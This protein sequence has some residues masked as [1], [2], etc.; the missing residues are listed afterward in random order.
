MEQLYEEERQA[1]TDG[2]TDRLRDVQHRIIGACKTDEE[3]VAALRLLTN[4]RKQ[5]PSCIKALIKT[6]YESK[7]PIGF[8]NALL[9]DVIESKIYLEEERLYISEHIKLLHGNNIPEAYEAVRHVPVETFTSVNERSRNAFLFE[10]FRLALLLKLYHDAELI[11]KR[12][13]RSY[14]SAEEKA[15]F[16]NYSILLKIGKKAYLEV[17]RLYLELNACLPNRKNV[18]MGAFFCMLSSCLVENRD[19]LG[20]KRELL[21]EF[22]ENKTNDPVMRTHVKR[23]CSDLV[24]EMSLVDM[25]DKSINRIGGGLPE[26]LMD[27]YKAELRNSVTEHNVSVVGKF[28][29]KIGIA[30][31]SAV[32]SLPVDDIIDFISRMVNE[33]FCS[34]KINQVGML[35]DFGCKKWNDDVDDVLDKIVA[36]S[37]LIHRIQL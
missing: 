9:S 27:V 10:Q 4:K 13:R 12:V 14:M 16:Y 7:K 5:E 18:A 31:L 6:L 19:V 29:S 1:R 37:N 35:V 11:G 22:A 28:V 33:K 36:A 23:F 30:E 17:S 3:I 24:L 25:I 34:I 32:L 2:K 26:D 20:E 15:V 21:M 8:Y